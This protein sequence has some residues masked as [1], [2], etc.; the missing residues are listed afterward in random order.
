MKLLDEVLGDALLPEALAVDVLEVG[1]VVVEGLPRH[2]LELGDLEP[3]RLHPVCA[4]VRLD[5]RHPAERVQFSL[6][7]N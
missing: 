2:V 6:L 3:H 7:K 5:R 4:R 1:A